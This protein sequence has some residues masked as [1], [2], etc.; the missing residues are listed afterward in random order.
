MTDNDLRLYL[1]KDGRMYKWEL[2]IVK[3]ICQLEKHSSGIPDPDKYCPSG[4]PTGTPPP[5]YPPAK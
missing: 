2:D 1:G 5:S 4:S 3:A